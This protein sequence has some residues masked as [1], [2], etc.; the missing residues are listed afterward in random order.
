MADNMNCFSSV[1]ESKETEFPSIILAELI[2]KGSLPIALEIN[3]LQ[4][5]LDF[6][7]ILYPDQRLCMV[8]VGQM[9]CAVNEKFNQISCNCKSN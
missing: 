5:L 6:N 1:V 7:S 4:M 2:W 3:G 8:P 9:F